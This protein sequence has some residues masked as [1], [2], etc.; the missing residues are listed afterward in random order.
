[1]R[2]AFYMFGMELETVT[3]CNSLKQV[4]RHMNLAKINGMV[5]NN[6]L[7][8]RSHLLHTD[9][10]NSREAMIINEIQ[11]KKPNHYLYSNLLPYSK[12]TL[13]LTLTL[14]LTLTST[15]CQSQTLVPTL[16]LS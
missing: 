3:V 14:S 2:F 9:R 8:M 6:I 10:K 12:K 4:G 15:L 5:V 13:T 11:T 1:M 7:A 16:T